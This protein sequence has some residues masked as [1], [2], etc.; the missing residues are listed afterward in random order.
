MLASVVGAIKNGALVVLGST[1]PSL[2]DYYDTNFVT[3]IGQ[4]VTTILGWVTSNPILALFFTM[5][6]I[7]FGFVIISW[8]KGVI[9]VK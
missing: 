8:L 1:T 4:L 3:K 6:M 2:S 5:T 7:S 9:R